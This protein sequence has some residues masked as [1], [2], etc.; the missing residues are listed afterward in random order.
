M[1][2]V[3][4][5]RA[6]ILCLEVCLGV[7]LVA[8][9]GRTP[10]NRNTSPDAGGDAAAPDASGPADCQHWSEDLEAANRFDINRLGLGVSR[11]VAEGTLD[12]VLD[13]GDRHF[14]SF[15]VDRIWYGK[16]FMEGHDTWVP[17]DE[18][19]LASVTLPDSYVI[20]FRGNDFPLFDDD[21]Q[22]SVWW[23]KSAL[24]PS[25]ERE[26]Y[27]AFVGY[28][29]RQTPLV[30]AVRISDQDA[31]RTWFEVTEPLQGD[32]PPVFGDN[33]TTS[34]FPVD[35]PPPSA[36]GYL[37]SVSGLTE[38]SGQHIGSVLD[39]REDT[40][41]NRALVLADLA[42]PLEFWAPNASER[43]DRYGLGWSYKIAPHVVS[44]EVSG[45]ADECCTGAGGTFV[46]HDINE[47]LQ[48]ITAR[49]F[50]VTGGHGYYGPEVCGDAYL[51]GIHGL[52][53]LEGLAPTDFGCDPPGVID[54]YGPFTSV[55]R[56]LQLDGTAENRQH[57][58][59]WLASDPALFRLHPPDAPVAPEHV[60]QTAPTA[61]WSVPTEAELAILAATHLSW[62]T[63]DQVEHF[64]ASDHYEV[65]FSTTFTKYRHDHQT[66][67]RAKLAFRCGDTRLLREGADWLA[68]ILFDDSLYLQGEDPIPY[69]SGLLVPGLL[70]PNHSYIRQVI[71][72][73][74]YSQ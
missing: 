61:L 16:A 53:L 10:G 48:G 19:E 50:T 34:I 66:L 59:D 49:A 2:R 17:F 65:T 36:T 73:L 14:V 70:L 44:T 29:S 5:C 47:V 24:I 68:P 40:P 57:V 11:S 71:T 33:W 52:D 54:A 58:T 46:A 20:G 69:L 72:A 4:R 38:Y 56:V 41:A 37:A 63:I 64:A 60:L 45:L 15:H 67:Y 6:V 12:Q 32:F 39:F 25:A 62:I 7:F 74:G 3:M 23:Q 27:G 42:A 21:L 55:T 26:D 30:A 8:C 22:D 51:L 35:F 31:D 28:Q 18:L 1:D 9:G 13:Q 43:A